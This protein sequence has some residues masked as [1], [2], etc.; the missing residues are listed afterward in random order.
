M[1]R[2]QFGAREGDERQRNA[3]GRA[4]DK[5]LELVRNL[6]AER[7][8]EQNPDSDVSAG[9]HARHEEAARCAMQRREF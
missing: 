6:R 2:E 5:F 3:K 7:E 8:D 1:A 9:E 4:H